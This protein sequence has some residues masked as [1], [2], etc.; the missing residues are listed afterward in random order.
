MSADDPAKL[1]NFQIRSNSYMQRLHG[2]SQA[3]GKT[4]C[5]GP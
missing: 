3:Y 1:F 5:Q 4:Q 2:T